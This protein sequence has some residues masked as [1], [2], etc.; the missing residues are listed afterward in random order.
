MKYSLEHVRQSCDDIA[1]LIHDIPFDYSGFE[2]ELEAI[3]KA[4][5][6]FFN[7]FSGLTEAE[8]D[9]MLQALE[10]A[11][12]EKIRAALQKQLEDWL[13]ENG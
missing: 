7:R 13:K 8:Y 6:S 5:K 4:C 12:S 10:D 1:Y 9:K 2:Q 3:T 11:G